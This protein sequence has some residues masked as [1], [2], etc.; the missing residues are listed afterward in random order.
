VLGG[1]VPVPL[2]AAAGAVHVQDGCEEELRLHGHA[3][4]GHLPAAT[5][6][7]A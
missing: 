1:G 2:A 3:G 7:H 4:Q 6:S 5:A